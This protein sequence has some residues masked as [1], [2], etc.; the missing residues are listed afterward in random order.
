MIFINKF[1]RIGSREQVYDTLKILPRYIPERKT[2]SAMYYWVNINWQ[3]YY[4]VYVRPYLIDS[5]IN[6]FLVRQVLYIKVIKYS[7]LQQ[8]QISF[9][10]IFNE[11]NQFDTLCEI[12]NKRYLECICRDICVSRHRTVYMY[13]RIYV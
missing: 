12:V 11:Q 6:H 1:T 3:K 13:V 4:L 5:K 9:K 7:V 2:E 10:V 8:S